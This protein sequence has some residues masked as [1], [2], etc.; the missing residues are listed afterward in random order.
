[1]QTD[2][3]CVV[4][5]EMAA[6][7]D[8]WEEKMLLCLRSRFHW[9][10]MRRV[11]V[12]WVCSCSSCSAHNTPKRRGRWTPLVSTG[13]SFPW[14]RVAMDPIPNLAVTKRGNRHLLGIVDYF[15]KW[16]GAFLLPDM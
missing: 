15:T 16:A 8:V 9:Y 14:E 5:V 12:D 4:C 13:C 1:M 3:A 10:G 6:Q 7:I 11:V 2:A